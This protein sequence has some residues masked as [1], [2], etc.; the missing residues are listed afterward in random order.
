LSFLVPNY[1]FL[2]PDRVHL[3]RVITGEYKVPLVVCFSFRKHRT[4]LA[5]FRLLTTDR[6]TTRWSGA[7][8]ATQNSDGFTIC[9]I[10]SSHGFSFPPPDCL[11]GLSP[12][13]VL[14]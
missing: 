14:L 7:K 9:K 8:Y 11:H 4:G 1:L 6:P 12:G 3:V 10:L 13:P 2:P 5:S